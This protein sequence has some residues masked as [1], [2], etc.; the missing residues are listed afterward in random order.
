MISKALGKTIPITFS[1][2]FPG[3]RGALGRRSQTA[4]RTSGI[5]DAIEK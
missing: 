4:M 3:A 2:A 1:L 5:D